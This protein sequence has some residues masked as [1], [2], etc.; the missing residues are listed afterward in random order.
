MG[1]AIIHVSVASRVGDSATVAEA[2]AAVSF[3]LNN[4]DAAAGPICGKTVALFYF[5]D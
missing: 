5:D 1:L 2:V 3:S 4:D